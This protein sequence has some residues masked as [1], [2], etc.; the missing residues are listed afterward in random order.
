MNHDPG[1]H[2]SCD[3]HL[4]REWGQ[5]QI[6]PQ[7]DDVY[8]FIDGLAAVRVGDDARGKYGFI[9][10]TGEMVI[11][12]EFDDVNPFLE[13]L[14]AIQIGDEWGFIDTAGQVV[15]DPQFDDVSGFE[16]SPFLVETLH[17]S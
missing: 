10:T 7:F 15:I 8:G 4:S 16:S 2:L 14:A 17:G 5:P 9:D 13:G 3:E 12:P 1:F 11:T 6:D